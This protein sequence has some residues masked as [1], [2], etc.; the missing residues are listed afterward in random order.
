MCVCVCIYIY[1]G[2]IC[3]MT[4][5]LMSSNYSCMA[6]QWYDYHSITHTK[7]I[8]WRHEGSSGCYSKNFT[9][10]FR[11]YLRRERERER[12]KTFCYLFLT[13]KST[14][15][16]NFS[17]LFLEWK[18]A[19]FGEFLFPSSGVFHCTHSNGICRTGLLTA[20]EQLQDGTAFHPEP[21]P[22]GHMKIQPR[23]YPAQLNKQP[24]ASLHLICLYCLQL[25]YPQL[26]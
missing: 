24:A 22:S 14:R 12:D 5:V 8:Q 13:T 20:F 6:N 1:I 4:N 21:E 17:N 16:T 26:R 18:S 9:A 23:Q 10:N 2:C 19:C 25:Q 15:C 11:Q 7:G 3:I